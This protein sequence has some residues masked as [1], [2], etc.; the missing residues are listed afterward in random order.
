[1][2]P[3]FTRMLARLTRARGLHTLSVVFFALALTAFVFGIGGNT[4]DLANITPGL[5]WAVLL[6]SSLLGL[7]LLLETDWADSTLDDFILSPIPLPALM[8]LKM[9]A[10][11]AATALPAA[12]AATL[13]VFA[14]AP[15]AFSPQL[16]IGLLLGGISFSAIG[17]LGAALTL[18]SSRAATLQAVIVM[19][20]AVPP[21]IFGAGA[22]GAP[23]LG[24]S[25]VMPLSMLAAFTVS[26]A[27]LAPFAAAAIVRMKVTTP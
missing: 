24:V 15:D 10:H 12:I 3:I 14:M 23:L 11:I 17:M 4:S 8:A 21:L 1:M 19:P 13:C 26:A 6:L 5:V 7:P 9:L 16:G 25:P 18:G 22:A 27:T 20:L 2:M